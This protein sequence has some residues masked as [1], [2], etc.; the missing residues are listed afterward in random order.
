MIRHTELKFAILKAVCMKALESNETGCANET[1]PP[2]AKYVKVI[3]VFK[4]TLKSRGYV[5]ANV[6]RVALIFQQN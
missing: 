2:N 1:E 6:G 4:L 5:Y 3:S